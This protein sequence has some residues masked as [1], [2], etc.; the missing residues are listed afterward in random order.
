MDSGGFG[1][2]VLDLGRGEWEALQAGTG[3]EIP[4]T[5]ATRG[6]RCPV[7]GPGTGRDFR[8][9]FSE[10]EGGLAPSLTTLQPPDS[11]SRL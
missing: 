6:H 1:G 3:E 4:A 2:R 11:S 9:G 7:K 5:V 10:T 8:G